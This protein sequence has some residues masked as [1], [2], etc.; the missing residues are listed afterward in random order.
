MYWESQKIKEP[1]LFLLSQVVLALPVTQVSVERA[2]S[3]LKFILSDL[4][5]NL[6]ADIL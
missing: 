3:G 1:E 6:S 2:Y 5:S 4:R